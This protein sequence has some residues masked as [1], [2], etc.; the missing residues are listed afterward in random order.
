MI[1]D[2]SVFSLN[3]EYAINYTYFATANK[4]EKIINLF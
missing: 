2:K 1:Y 4:Y 3:D